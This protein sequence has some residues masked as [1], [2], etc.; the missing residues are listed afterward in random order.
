MCVWTG[1]DLGFSREGGCRFSKVLL[2]FFYVDQI[3]FLSSPETLKGPHFRQ[4]SGKK[5]KAKI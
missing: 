4:I 2:A 1:V 3:I 5:N